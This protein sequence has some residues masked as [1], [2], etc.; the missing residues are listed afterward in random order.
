MAEERS[1]TDV[2]SDEIIRK[3]FDM[4]YRLALSQTRNVSIAE[5]VTQDVFLRFL[6]NDGFET[7]EHIKAWLIRVT[8]NCSRSVFKT[9]WFR[10]TIPLEEEIAFDTPEKSDVYFAV[11]SLPS[12]YRAVIHLFYYE[13]MSVKEIADCLEISEP[14]VKTRLHRA[15]KQLK[16]KLKG[17]YDF[18]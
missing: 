1:R 5:D 10:K 15:R 12:H 17:G 13:D 2:S 4:V 18:V 7:D 11:Q 6:Q 16:T 8:I 9:A 3:Y 14:T